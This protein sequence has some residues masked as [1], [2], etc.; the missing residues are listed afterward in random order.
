MRGTGRVG[1]IHRAV[2][3]GALVI[4]RKP[5]FRGAQRGQRSAP[6]DDSLRASPESITTTGS[7][8][9]G[10]PRSLSSGRALRG[11]VGGFRNDKVEPP[12]R[13]QKLQP[14]L[15]PQEAATFAPVWI[16][17]RSVRRP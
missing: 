9:S 4:G 6:P 1:E 13:R 7:M 10:Q 14:L 3:A 5:S 16:G 15:A 8:D 11:P 2:C 12:V 17:L